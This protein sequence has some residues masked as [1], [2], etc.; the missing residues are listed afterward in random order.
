MSRFR[1]Q[2][3]H[4]R[5]IPKQHLLEAHCVPVIVKWGVGR[6]LLGEKRG[7]GDTCH[8]ERSQ[9]ERIGTEVC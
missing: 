4:I 5:V 9:K 7:R 6:A 8:S 2:F 3:P 1:H